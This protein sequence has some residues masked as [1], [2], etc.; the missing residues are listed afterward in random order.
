MKSIKNI[1]PKHLKKYIVNQNYSQYNEINQST[2]RFI[3]KISIDFFKKYGHKIYI[4]GL[5]KT[6]ITIDKIPKISDINNKLNKFNWSAIPVRGFI[7]PNAFMEFQ[8]LKILPIAADMRTHKHLTYT[9]APDIVHEAAGHAPIIVNKDYSN[10]LINYGEVANK[11][12]MSSEDMELYYA[13]RA[14]SDIKEKSNVPENEI[15]KYSQKLKKAY[16]NITYTSESALLSRMNWWTVEYGLIG[17]INNY[18]IYGAGLLSSVEESENCI[19]DNI[20]KIP[21]SI[22]C[23]NYKY[24][25][26]EQQPQLFITKN[27]KQ[28]SKVLEQLSNKMSFKVGGAY[29]LR[30]AIKA[31]TLCTIEI[32][33]NIQISGVVENFISKNNV[34]IFVKTIGKTQL[35]FNNKELKNHGIDYHS[36]GYSCPIGK[37]KKYKKSIN[38][39][40]SNEIKKLNIKI[41][42]TI[43]LEFLSGIKLVGTIKSLNKKLSKIIIIKFDNCTVK[44]NNKFLFKPD[45]GDFDLICGESI[46][47]VYGGVADKINYN[48]EQYKKSKYEYLNKKNLNDNNIQLNKLHKQCR[49]LEKEYSD[50]KILKLF[51]EVINDYPEEWLILYELLEIAN[52]YKNTKITNKIMASLNKFI[53]NKSPES[54]VI[55]RALHL[56]K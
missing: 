12:I 9:P 22:D 13:I 14:L 17:D 18:K 7:P 54:N 6:G 33:Q 52:T 20:K 41:N 10:Y 40:S 51:N 34:P 31:K 42:K 21:L 43:T 49:I 55:K 48:K 46:N 5:D 32:D 24:D 1:I 2:W 38:K 11:A 26:T 16:E 35:C 44:Y 3:M 36:N 8:S 19:S 25:I 27:F 28:L 39:L 30:Q 4:D 45:W 50:E 23:I 47:S 37:L 29:G 15:K 56:I 53:N